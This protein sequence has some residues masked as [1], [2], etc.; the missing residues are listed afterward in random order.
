MGLLCAQIDMPLWDS[1]VIVIGAHFCICQG[2]SG[3]SFDIWIGHNKVYVLH[4]WT[5]VSAQ[6]TVKHVEYVHNRYI[7]WRRVT[8]STLNTVL[9]VKTE[10][11]NTVFSRRFQQ[12]SSPK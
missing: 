6:F 7:S 10:F 2:S 11:L 4:I 12:R 3:V 1:N 9:S 5:S 8:N